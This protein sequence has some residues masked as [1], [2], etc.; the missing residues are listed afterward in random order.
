MKKYKKSKNSFKKRK[1]RKFMFVEKRL[2]HIASNAVYGQ[3]QWRTCEREV[4]AA[5][6]IF[7]VFFPAR[8]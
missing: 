3:L 6:R 5:K 2:G 4:L 7:L 8:K 1:I